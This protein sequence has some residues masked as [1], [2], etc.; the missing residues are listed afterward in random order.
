MSSKRLDRTDVDIKRMALSRIGT[1]L[2]HA[3]ATI[4]PK[5]TIRWIAE[6][7]LG[8][9]KVIMTRFKMTVVKA[10][11]IALVVMGLVLGLVLVDSRPFVCCSVYLTRIEGRVNSIPSTSICM[12][13]KITGFD[14][15]SGPLLVAMKTSSDLVPVIE[16]FQQ[17]A[18]FSWTR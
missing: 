5:K 18:W 17:K 12:T 1:N 15:I 16:G 8:L 2:N 13:G 6:I 4:I 9:P 10:L 14:T 3:A 11:A 7:V